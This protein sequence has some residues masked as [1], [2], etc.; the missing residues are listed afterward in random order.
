MLALWISTAP[1]PI[2]HP[3][4]NSLLKKSGAKPQGLKPALILTTYAALMGYSRVWVERSSLWREKILLDG[5]VKAVDGLSQCLILRNQRRGSR[6]GPR[7]NS[8]LTMSAE[9][10]APSPHS[11]V[12]TR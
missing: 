8:M 5:S 7:R 3:G 4:L 10:K 12:L 6:V 2:Q 1:P 9:K 11:G